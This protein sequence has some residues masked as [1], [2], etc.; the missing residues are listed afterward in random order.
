MA[1]RIFAILFVF[2]TAC[3]SAQHTASGLDQT[4]QGIWNQRQF[5]GFSVAIVN[6]DGILYE[7]G[8]GWA[9]AEDK[10][11]YTERT[12]QNIASISKTLVGLALVKA[13]EL[14]QLQLDDPIDGYLPFVVRNP[15][16]PDIPITIRHLATHTASISDNAYYLTRNYILK[17]GQDLRG[18]PLALE[19]EQR[20]NP[21]D[22]LM[23]MGTFLK[24]MLTPGGQ[25]NDTDT[26]LNQKPGAVFEYSNVATA[27]A[28][29]VLERATG[30]DFAAFTRQHILGPLHMEASGWSFADTDF[31]RYSCLYHSVEQRLPFYT[32]ITYP[33]GNFITSAH[34]L[35]LFLSELIKGYNGRGTLLSES[36]YRTYFTPA[37]T[38]AHF[39]ERNTLNPYSDEYNIGVFIGFSAAGNI[40]HTGGDPGVSSLMSFDP[41]TGVGRLLIVN[42]NIND[43][44]GNDAFYAIWDALWQANPIKK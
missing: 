19:D 21:P 16:F 20:L 37:L 1:V 18:L 26:F 32:T 23:S 11:P 10:R 12:I 24:G 44:K 14:D 7:K 33:D 17:P 28:A 34:D 31:S 6:A 9:D 35:G 13:Q 22:S 36:G 2:L 5:N 30:L 15:H 27:L 8:T 42:T 43:K 41:K 38:D 3:G 4:L 39:R 25:W 29:Y 40:G